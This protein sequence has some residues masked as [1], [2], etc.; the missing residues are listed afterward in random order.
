MCVIKIK[1][2]YKLNKSFNCDQC[3]LVLYISYLVIVK[4][5]YTTFFDYVRSY[6]CKLFNLNVSNLLVKFD[7]LPDL[8]G[9]FV[10]NFYDLQNI[11]VLNVE[12][13]IS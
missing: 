12:H 1:Y 8:F 13:L 9:N 10:N 3:L 6:N 2:K 7:I 4:Y 5:Y 11:I